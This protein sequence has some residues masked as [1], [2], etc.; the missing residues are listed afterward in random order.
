MAP[1]AGLGCRVAM[2]TAMDNPVVL[3]ECLERGAVGNISKLQSLEALVD[4]ID[5]AVAGRDLISPEKRDG[6]IAQDVP[7]RRCIRRNAGWARK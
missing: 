1:L 7:E 4:A 5:Y 2:F 3:G 6:L